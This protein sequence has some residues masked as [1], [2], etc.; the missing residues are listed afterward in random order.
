M[1]LNFLPF[2]S[3]SRFIIK[4]I[5]IVNNSVN[6]HVEPRLKTSKCPTC[7][8]KS[9]SVHSFYKRKIKDL[10][11][12][13]NEVIINLLCKKFFCK[14]DECDR[15][16]FTERFTEQFKPYSR[17][18][19]RLT[20]KILRTGLLTGG[21][22]GSRISRLHC[23]NI[24]ASTI[25]RIVHKAPL[26]ES[27]TPKVLG[28]DDW[29]YKKGDRYETALVDLEKH[30]I[31]ELLPD[32]DSNTIKNWLIDNPGVEIITR[33]RYSNYAKG[34]TEGCPEAT[35]IAD[36]FHLLQN[37]SEALK[38]V[39]NRNYKA[40]KQMFATTSHIKKCE[41]INIS[42]DSLSIGLTSGY[43][44]RLV[45]MQEVKMRYQKGESLRKIA[46]SVWLNRKTVASYLQ[47]EEPPIKA[48]PAKY[49]FSKF[50]SYILEFINKSED[51][52][53]KILI[54]EMKKIGY[55]GG[56][57]TAYK[58]IRENFKVHKGKSSPTLPKHLYFPAKAALLLS[59]SPSKLSSIQND[60]VTKICSAAPD[61]KQA[62]ILSRQFRNLLILKRGKLT[63]RFE[64]WIDKALKCKASEIR[65]FAKGLLSDISAV[66]NA[67]LLKWS[68]GQVEG[69]INK[70]KTIKR[71]MYGRCS[72]NLLKRRLIMSFE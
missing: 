64:T 31:I 22:L 59:Q 27:V 14:N 4:V 61:I 25:L 38:K 17:M 63:N 57:T 36:R 43:N 19:I 1:N 69:Q 39:L 46:S 5:S 35:Q 41:N 56:L 42:S 55:S 47:L 6:L 34:A 53:I 28:I 26:K 7:S 20:N 52:P 72:F 8:R 71:Q 48:S 9:S 30:R 32:R 15:S 21:N 37:L 29:A 12:F 60:I 18:S 49:N 40:Y 11:A 68:N 16:I 62:C 70:L 10:P 50:T 2:V 66:R 24:S 58:F 67:I 65:S 45:Q 23:I 44:K 33:D 51:M 13:G 54:N 3:Q